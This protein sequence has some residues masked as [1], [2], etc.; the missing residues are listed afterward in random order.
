M[1]D[2]I[3][4]VLAEAANKTVRSYKKSLTGDYPKVIMP[5]G[6]AHNA[7]QYLSQVYKFRNAT[8]IFSKPE[9]H[10]ED[11]EPGYHY[12]WAEF[13][14]GGGRPREGA[15]RTEAFIRKGV[16][17][18]VEPQE[19]KVD[20]EIPFSKG[21]T[22]KRVEMYDVMLVKIPPKA[23]SEMYSVR[24]AMGVHAV[25]RHFDGFYNGVAAQ[26]AVAD[27]EANIEPLS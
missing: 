8:S 14:V 25:T 5:G 22:K 21:V 16:Y 18:A 4:E 24:E 17:I 11:P 3:S 19:M 7:T 13:H 27:V 1:P 23:W 12:A 26:G 2:N 15:L 20:S 9:D 6:V 10:I